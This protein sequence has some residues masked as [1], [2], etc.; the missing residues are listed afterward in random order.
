MFDEEFSIINMIRNG[1]MAYLTKSCELEKLAIV[2]E[3]VH[4]KGFYHD[5]IDAEL[6]N[7]II[8]SAEVYS[9]FTDKEIEFLYLCCSD[10]NYEKIGECMNVSKRTV[11]NYRDSLFKK[12][13]L[14]TRTGLA[15]FAMLTGYGPT[16]IPT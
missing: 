9:P 14:K 13:N 8:H 16:A 7:K 11:E 5:D 1:A 12:L 3:Q 2:L 4:E 15:T 6:L 10:L